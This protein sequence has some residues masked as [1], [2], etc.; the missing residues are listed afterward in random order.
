MNKYI[1]AERI[2]KRIIVIRGQKVML[3]RDLAELYGVRTKVLNQAVK[4]NKKRFP[5]DFMFQLSK[6]EQNQLVTTCV[7][8]K[9]LLKPSLR[10]QIVTLKR[11]HHLKYVPFVFTEQGVAMLSSVLNSERAISVNIQIMRTFTKL[12]QILATHADLRKRLESMEKKYDQQF[13]VVFEAIKKLIDPPKPK[14][15]KIGFLRESEE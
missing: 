14:K 5:A 9:K 12:R 2:E 10:S 7:R 6:T 8:F 1:P 11:G 15:G 13:Q 3:D 4:R